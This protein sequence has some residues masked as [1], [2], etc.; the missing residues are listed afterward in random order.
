[1]HYFRRKRHRNRSHSARRFFRSNTTD[2]SRARIYGHS[3]R[4]GSSGWTSSEDE[5]ESI[6]SIHHSSPRLRH[7]ARSLSS[8]PVATWSRQLR[9]ITAPSSTDIFQVTRHPCSTYD[10][11]I[12]EY[13][14]VHH[15]EGYLLSDTCRRKLSRCLHPDSMVITRKIPLRYRVEESVNT[16]HVATFKPSHCQQYHTQFSQDS[17]EWQSSRCGPEKRRVRLID[18]HSVRS[19]E[20]IDRQGRRIMY[21][22]SR[23][24]LPVDLSW[25]GLIRETGS[26]RRRRERRASGYVADSMRHMSPGGFPGAP[27]CS[28]MRFAILEALLTLV[29][30]SATGTSTTRQGPKKT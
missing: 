29:N 9:L 19:S 2:R 1:M 28:C 18:R 22:R 4:T 14:S 15:D 3:R 24:V 10:P 30:Q 27:Y 23:D 6:N 11:S 21:H 16:E 13:E 20:G 5:V 7:R 17:D 26:A 8:R 12:H 25:D